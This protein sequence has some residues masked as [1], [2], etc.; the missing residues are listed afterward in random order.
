MGKRLRTQRRGSGCPHYRSPSHRHVDDVRIP[1]YEGEGT[2]RDLIQAPGRTSPLAVIDYADGR[3]SYQL[4][5]EGTAVG[6]KVQIGGESV[7]PGNTLILSNIHEGT[8]VHNIEGQ[9]GDGGK[10]VKTAGT[11]ALVVSNGRKVVLSM[12]SGELKEFDPRCR[13][14]VGVVA[15]GGRVDK[16][17]G[18]A[19]K[20]YLTLRSRSVA[21]KVTSGVAMNAVDHPHGGG[22]HPHVGGPNCHGRNAPP[23]QKAGFIAPKK[24][25]KRK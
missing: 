15:G 25:V 10:F 16:P 5:V 3:K 1:H 22:S 17:L 18:K 14:V 2:I 21:N 11:S 12:P 7:K 23:G 8:L 4:A 19:G 24:K 9:P 13:A 20:N 6:Q